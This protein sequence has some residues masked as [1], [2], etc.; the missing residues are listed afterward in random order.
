MCHGQASCVNSKWH[1]KESSAAGS[2]IT[3]LFIVPTLIFDYVSPRGDRFDVLCCETLLCRCSSRKY[4]YVNSTDKTW[5]DMVSTLSLTQGDFFYPAFM[6]SS[7]L[8]TL[9]PLREQHMRMFSNSLFWIYI[10]FNIFFFGGGGVMI[11]APFFH[12]TGDVSAFDGGSLDKP[13]DA[14]SVVIVFWSGKVLWCGLHC[15]K[16]VF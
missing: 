5:R 14:I 10:E 12:L 7:D 13:V 15:G 16:G 8:A 1:I 2:H 9:H 6:L 3:F 11:S 4:I